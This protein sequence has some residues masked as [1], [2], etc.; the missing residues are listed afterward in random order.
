[1]HSSTG[2]ESNNLT[3][4]TMVF[5]LVGVVKGVFICFAL[6]AVCY[7]YSDHTYISAV[8]LFILIILKTT[9]ILLKFLAFADTLKKTSNTI[10][11]LFSFIF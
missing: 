10:D 6:M 4:L 2:G 5:I 11:L 3:T 8:K 9:W 7:R 1:V